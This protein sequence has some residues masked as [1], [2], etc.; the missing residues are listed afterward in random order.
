MIVS[1]APGTIIYKNC[2][3]TGICVRSLGAGCSTRRGRCSDPPLSHLRRSCTA[4]RPIIT[5]VEVSLSARGLQVFV[6]PTTAVSMAQHSVNLSALP[7]ECSC[8]LSS[9]GRPHLVLPTLRAQER[10]ERALTRSHAF[11]KSSTNATAPNSSS[12]ARY[13]NL[14]ISSKNF[15]T[16]R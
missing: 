16:V 4:R 6:P 7:D 11:T 8:F 3:A 10:D 5:N 12:P 2:V 1:C 15:Q 9:W 13:M 14:S